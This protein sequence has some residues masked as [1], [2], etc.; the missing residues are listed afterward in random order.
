MTAD[1]PVDACAEYARR[2]AA[3]LGLVD[4]L[5]SRERILSY[6]RLIAFIAA[7]GVAWLAV[8]TAVCS[9][10]WGLL[11]LGVFAA[12]VIAHHRARNARERAARAAEFY[13]RGLA[14]LGDR[15]IGNGEAGE[16]F[17]DPAHPYAEDLDLFGRGSLYELLCTVRTRAGEETLAAW[18]K[19]PATPDEIRTRQTAIDELR[20]CV[21]LREDLWAIGIDVRQ[22]VNPDALSAWGEQP[23]LL[24][25]RTLRGVAAL[26]AILAVL[27]LVGWGFGLGPRPFA[28]VAMCG[29][30]IGLLLRSRVRR[31]IREVERPAR[32]LALLAQLLG[33]VE[34]ERF[35]APRLVGLR[36]ALDTEGVPP[37]RRVARL[38]RW[39]ELLDARRNELFAPITPLLLWAT[40]CALAI[41][42]WRAHNG[43]AIVRWLGAVGEIE[44]L[45][46]LAG[47]AY[48]R[49]GDVFPEIVDDAPCFEA[50]DLGHPLIPASRCVR[51]PVRLGGEL[52]ALVVSGSN[53]SGK[54]TLLRTVGANTVLALM[55]APVRARRLRLSPLRVGASIRSHDSLQAGTSR[56]Y[57]EIS[58]LRQLVDLT[59]ASAPLLFLL[60]EILH[61]TNSH[62]RRIGAESV[63]RG[64]LARG[65][66]GVVTTHDLALAQIADGVRMINVHFEDHIENGRMVFDYLMRPGVVEK[67][68]ALALMRAI[69]LDV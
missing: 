55:G 11:P 65:A 60:D 22:G 69:G 54:S 67:S 64:F 38:V 51:N 13:A 62:D 27:T 68:N 33:R 9:P 12:L 61:G 32:D 29:A 6:C 50:M 45:C 36:A 57:E 53:M 5:T 7:G 3:R 28:G 34:R 14:R 42:A 15:W 47:Y 44:A 8:D 35:S 59:D 52:R 39:I 24:H 46:A 25:S 43:A 1:S 4:R 18:L 23:Q 41:E 63:V 66:I 49:P 58:R 20:P 37:S 19:A 10:W 56:F 31:V 26:L 30:A 40:Q 17:R 48:E 21:D 2:H 16:R